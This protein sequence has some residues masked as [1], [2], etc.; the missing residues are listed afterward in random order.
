MSVW[1]CAGSG[2]AEPSAPG[3]LPQG[4]WHHVCGTFDVVDGVM[5]YVDGELVA[6]AEPNGNEACDGASLPRAGSRSDGQFLNAVIDEVAIWERALS[7]DEVNENMNGGLA[8]PVELRG[9]L[10]TSWGLVKRRH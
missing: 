10:A 4:E 8:T 9:K 2:V 7:I 6:E 5:L 1:N 3:T